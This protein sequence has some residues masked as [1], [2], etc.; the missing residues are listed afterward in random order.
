MVL[1]FDFTPFMNSRA[2]GVTLLT[3]HTKF[4][5]TGKYLI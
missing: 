1:T 4:A 3:V 2:I 5:Y